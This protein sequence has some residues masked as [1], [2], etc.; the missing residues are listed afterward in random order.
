MFP[1]WPSLWS[2]IFRLFCL[3]YVFFLK[4]QRFFQ[5][6]LFLECFMYSNWYL[7][8]NC[9]GIMLKLPLTYSRT[10]AEKWRKICQKTDEKTVFWRFQ[11]TA[12]VQHGLRFESDDM[13]WVDDGQHSEPLFL[14]H[15]STNISWFE[16]LLSAQEVLLAMH[17]FIQ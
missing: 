14:A 10:V 15:Q 9:E 1:I 2:M 4:L 8:H 13:R 5:E 11:L 16:S 3:L 17:V 6:S 12:D 7:E